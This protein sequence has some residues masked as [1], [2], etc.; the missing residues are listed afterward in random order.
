MIAILSALPEEC[1]S[2][3]TALQDTTEHPGPVTPVIQGHFKNQKVI[4]GLTGVGKAMA[5]MNTQWI[6]DKFKP[7]LLILTGVAGAIHPDLNIG[8]LLIAR[9][10]VQHDLETIELK[11]PRGMVPYT[12]YRFLASDP[13]LFEIASGFHP[14]SGKLASGRILTGDQFITAIQRNTHARVFAELQ[15]DAVEMEGASVALVAQIHRVPFLI[16]RTI[17]DRADG[18]AVDDFNSFLPRASAQA[19]DF[20]EYM[21]EAVSKV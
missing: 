5:A 15:G 1:Q 9:D 12:Q 10:C 8:D 3:R 17:S 6:I 4:L 19:H 16:S 21:L 13:K 11:F 18:S 2:I 7:R 20:I 14:R